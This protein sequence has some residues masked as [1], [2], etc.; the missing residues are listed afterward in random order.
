MLGGNWPT[1]RGYLPPGYARMAESEYA[2]RTPC[3]WSKMV[4]VGHG[5]SAFQPGAQEEP[6][7]NRVLAVMK[8]DRLGHAVRRE[9]ASNPGTQPGHKTD[10][11]RVDDDICGDAEVAPAVASSVSRIAGWSLNNSS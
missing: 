8:L 2:R 5:I 1:P 10:L 3:R 7:S 9:V 6:Q 11:V 4:H